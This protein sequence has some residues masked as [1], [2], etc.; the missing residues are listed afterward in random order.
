MRIAVLLCGHIRTWNLCKESLLSIL[1]HDADIFVHTYSKQYGYHPHIAGKIGVDNET[2]DR[3]ITS[4][5]QFFDSNRYVQVVVEDELTEDDVPDIKE[6]PV[7]LDI[8]SQIRKVR[9]CNEL[10]KDWEKKKSIHYDLV[11]KTRMDIV[12]TNYLSPSS[13]EPNTI[14]IPPCPEIFTP[15]DV[16]YMGDPNSM[17]LLIENLSKKYPIKIVDPHAW[18]SLCLKNFRVVELPCD[19][20]IKRLRC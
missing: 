16:C 2:N 12:Y 7:H 11:I 5:E 6:Y 10:R 18:L 3:L 9:L 1:P 15:S 4:S 17:N 8:Y 13:V 14:Y 20:I 19:C